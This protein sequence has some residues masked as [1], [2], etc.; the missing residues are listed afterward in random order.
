MW[1][2]HYD[3]R[4][5]AIGMRDLSFSLTSIRATSAIPAAGRGVV[6]AAVGRNFAEEVRPAGGVVINNH[7]EVKAT[8]LAIDNYSLPLSKDLCY[9]LSKPTV[10]A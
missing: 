1:L 9:Y 4:N 5:G 3:W 6:V 8:L 2:R 7:V 10:R